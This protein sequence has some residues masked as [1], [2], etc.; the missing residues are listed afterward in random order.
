MKQ[1]VSL[2]V[3]LILC[4]STYAQH[5]L[6]LSIKNSEG[7]PLAGTT[8]TLSPGQR[9]VAADS[10]GLAVFTNLTEGRYTLTLSFVGHE[11]KV[12]TLTVPQPTN[13]PVEVLLDESE[14]EE[15]E[16]EV[17]VRATRTSRTIANTPTR[18]EVISGEE[19]DEK[20]N[21]KP[22]DI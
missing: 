12:L 17:V 16:E 5:T 8:V 15:E 3:V 10:T 14:E 1:L 18:V 20:A 21:M 2:V 11:E 7:E 13:A 4:I 9:T 22:G 6:T 19:L